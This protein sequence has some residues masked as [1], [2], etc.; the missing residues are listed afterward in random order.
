[1]TAPYPFTAIVGQE[2]MKLAMAIAA[3]DPSVGGVLA[4]G[5]R[6]ARH[7]QVNRGA[8]PGG[9]ATAN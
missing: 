4:F 2:E 8:G 6:R 7:R 3:V 9:I 5:D 1:M